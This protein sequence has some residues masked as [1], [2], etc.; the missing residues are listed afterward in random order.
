[1]QIS[2]NRVVTERLKPPR[3]LYCEFPL[4][5]PLGHPG[6][7]QFQRRVLD[8][9]FALLDRKEG[10]VLEDFPET[11][12]DEGVEPLACPVPPRFDP[13]LPEAVDEAKALRPAYN[14][15]LARTERTVVGKV[16]GPDGVPDAV[17]VFV[18]LVEC[19]SWEELTR[20]GPSRLVAQ[21]IR[22]YY[23]EAAMELAGHV[24]EAHAAEAWFYQ[25]TAT[26]KLMRE[27]LRVMRDGGAPQAEWGF[28]VPRNFQ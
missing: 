24:P 21:D 11:I 16:L 2:S 7:A 3:A 6:D 9:A 12:D 22:G 8:T 13:S 4:G 20:L 18:R 28:L 10:P 17:G 23:E 15:Q 14:R 27:A 5:R 19:G 25:K 1:V 26:G